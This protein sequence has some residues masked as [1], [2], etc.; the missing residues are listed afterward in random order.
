MNAAMNCAIEGS[1]SW[2]ERGWAVSVPGSSSWLDAHVGRCFKGCLLA[3]G[4]HWSFHRSCMSPRQPADA[5]SLAFL[6]FLSGSWVVSES[7]VSRSHP[8]Q[9][10]S[11]SIC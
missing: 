3:S 5:F 9:L 8:C 4:I 1:R 2:L 6:P 10:Q 7:S 11:S